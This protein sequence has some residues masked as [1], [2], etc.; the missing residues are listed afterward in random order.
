LIVVHYSDPGNVFQVFLS[1]K[2]VTISSP[3]QVNTG[4]G[5][6]TWTKMVFSM[7]RP[8]CLIEAYARPEKY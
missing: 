7:Y 1:H 4:W 3:S 5:G 2:E 8:S 6:Q